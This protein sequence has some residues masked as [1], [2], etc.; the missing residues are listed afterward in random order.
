M[1]STPWP[2]LVSAALLPA[3]GRMPL[4]VEPVPEP[5]RSVHVTST[6]MG[7][8]W[9][10][11]FPQLIVAD[12]E[13]L[14][15]DQR[16]LPAA[17][18]SAQ[19]TDFSAAASTNRIRFRSEIQPAAT[20]LA[21]ALTIENTS[22]EILRNVAAHICL[23]H[24]RIEADGGGERFADPKHERTY[25]VSNRKLAGLNTIDR[26][27]TPDGLRSHYLVSGGSPITY[28]TTYPFWGRL[29]QAKADEPWIATTS[30]SG[31][32]TVGFYWE[33]AAELFQNSD[34]GNRCIHSSPAFGDL[35]P[36]QTATVRGGINLVRGTPVDALR[37]YRRERAAF[38]RRR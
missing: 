15:V 12:P 11:R 19:G 34:A 32:W 27:G 13:I 14:L 38:G 7:A 29:S 37:I 31:A 9:R 3:A 33:R 21:L 10:L 4:K 22:P 24:D 18:T 6:E 26:G 2:V 36:G 20:G 17:W 5:E 16:G 28:I 30:V 1:R 23:S 35:S 8:T 25:I